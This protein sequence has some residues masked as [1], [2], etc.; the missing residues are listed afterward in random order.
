VRCTCILDAILRVARQ[1][2]Q[3][4]ASDRGKIEDELE[5]HKG[6]P[7]RVPEALRLRMEDIRR[8][9]E[10]QGRFIA[11]QESEKAA[12]AGAWKRSARA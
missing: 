8:R 2:L 10:A 1:H 12:C 6:N 11:A 4:L 9:I 3:A 5:L 7:S